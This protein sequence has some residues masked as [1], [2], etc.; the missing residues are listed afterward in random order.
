M[1]RNE[2]TDDKYQIPSEFKE[3]IPGITVY[4]KYAKYLPDL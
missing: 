3:D 1:V 4:Q 2:Y